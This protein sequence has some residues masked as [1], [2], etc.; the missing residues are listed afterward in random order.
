MFYNTLVAVLLCILVRSKGYSFSANLR[1]IRSQSDLGR[2][3]V[4]GR[5][6]FVSALVLA[7]TVALVPTDAFAA[8]SKPNAKASA[9]SIRE[10]LSELQSTK[11]YL[12]KKKYDSLSSFLENDAEYLNNFSQSVTSLVQAKALSPDDT[13]SIGTI[14]TYGTAADVQIMLGGLKSELTSNDPNPKEVTKFWKR[15]EDSLKE[16]ILICDNA[17][18]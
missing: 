6:S 13:Q 5:R 15:A 18:I 11:P 12:D 3:R 4:V 10:A 2:N 1:E 16:I 7:P 9:N 8:S 17:S 14:R